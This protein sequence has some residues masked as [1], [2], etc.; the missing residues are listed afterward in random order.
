MRRSAWRRLRPSAEREARSAR[1]CDQ[2]ASRKPPSPPRGACLPPARLQEGFEQRQAR[3][4][5]HRLLHLHEPFPPVGAQPF[6][7]QDDAIDQ[8]ADV[9]PRH[10][11]QGVGHEQHHEGVHGAGVPTD[12]GL[13]EGPAQADRGQAVLHLVIGLARARMQQLALAVQ[14]PQQRAGR[15]RREVVEALRVVELH[16]AGVA[17]HHAAHAGGQR[18]LRQP[19]LAARGAYVGARPVRPGRGL[20][21]VAYARR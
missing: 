21:Q 1:L 19:E 3:L 11:V 10:Q 20:A 4:V 7:R 14:I 12:R 17:H 2:S 8:G 6:A 16:A 9:Q 18:R 13:R 15:R 5:V